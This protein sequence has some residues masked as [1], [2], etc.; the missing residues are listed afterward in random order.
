MSH[1]PIF[2]DLR[3]RS[4]VVIGGGEIAARKIEAL[5][6]AR[7][8]VTVVSPRVVERIQRWVEA[9]RVH[10]ERRRY[11]RGDLR[12]ACLAYCATGDADA[13]RVAR[14][15]AD[16]EGVWLNVA[17]DPALCDFFA[18]AVVRR[19]SLSVAISTNGASPALAARL[20]EKLEEDLGEEYAAVLGR[21]EA[22]RARCREE[23][24]P[25]SEV[26]EEI[27]RLIDQVLP[28]KRA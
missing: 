5:L 11:E 20:R 8:R 7:A 21:L 17:D 28:R 16:A 9:G 1:H 22:V 27:E 12:R 10:L 4:V 25:L 15:E 23:G 13:N 18:P 2:L 24:R 14:E 6:D 26:R 3:D 19:G